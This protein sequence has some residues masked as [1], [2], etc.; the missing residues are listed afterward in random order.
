[1]SDEMPAVTE[2][3]IPLAYERPAEP[4]SGMER[5]PGPVWPTLLCLPGM[6]CWAQLIGMIFGAFFGTRWFIWPGVVAWWALAV[7]TAVVSLFLYV[8]RRRPKP[9]YVCMNLFVNVSG[10]MFTICI[11]LL[12]AAAYGLSRR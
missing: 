6:A 11:L 12:I 9:W 4:V 2:Q 8:P 1:M 7:V 10:L 5:A 3:T